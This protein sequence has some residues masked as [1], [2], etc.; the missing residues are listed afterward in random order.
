MLVRDKPRDE[1]AVESWADAAADAAK[2]SVRAPTHTCC[3]RPFAVIPDD[4]RRW[5]VSSA[6]WRP[7]RTLAGPAGSSCAKRHLSAGLRQLA[8][9]LGSADSKLVASRRSLNEFGARATRQ[10]TAPTRQHRSAT[11]VTRRMR[12]ISKLPAPEQLHLF[13]K[14]APDWNRFTRFAASGGRERQVEQRRDRDRPRSI[15]IGSGAL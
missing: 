8:S 2:N 6:V 12:A 11:S 14:P 7:E 1:R 5:E 4:E 10:A 3:P 13:V 9:R 15:P